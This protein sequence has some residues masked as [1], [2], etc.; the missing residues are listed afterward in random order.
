MTSLRMNVSQ[1]SMITEK[2]VFQIGR[3]GK[4]HGFKGEVVMQIDDDIFDQVEADYLFLEIEGLLVPFFL[5]EY[6]FKSDTVVFMKFLDVETEE[7]ARRLTGCRV[8]FPR[9]LAD[10]ESP[11]SWSQIL[12]FRLIDQN[13]HEVGEIRKVD[14]STMNILF[15]VTTPDGRDLLIPASEE[16]IEQIDSE[17]QTL[18]VTLP[19]GIL[20]L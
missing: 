11:M 15:E 3:I 7:Q 16:L 1:F 2:D 19:E 13:G 8:L 10:D 14:D 20:N 18:T 5:E 9:E 12:G 6:R 4:P 17:E